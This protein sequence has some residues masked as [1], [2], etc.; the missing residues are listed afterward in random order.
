MYK[1]PWFEAMM[2]LS[3]TEKSKAHSFILLIWMG[4]NFDEDQSILFSYGSE[5]WTIFSLSG[6]KDDEIN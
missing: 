5:L 2:F 4:M 3:L 6:L 1:D